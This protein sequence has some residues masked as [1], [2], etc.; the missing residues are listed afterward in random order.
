M[1]RVIMGTVTAMVVALLA[2]PVAT[3]AQSVGKAPRIGFLTWE[4]CPTQD[5]VFGVALRSRGY[6]WGQSI[7]IVC[8]SAEGDYGRLSEAA[9]ALAAEKVD[10]IAALTHITAYAAHRA[11]RSIP[12]VM[13]TSGDPAPTCSVCTER[14][15]SVR[16][17]FWAFN[18]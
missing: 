3:E 10:A 16:R 7:H 17:G 18:S 4:T 12:I 13:I 1:M 11:T 8:R 2:G 6:T 5:S 14:M 9:G 15:R